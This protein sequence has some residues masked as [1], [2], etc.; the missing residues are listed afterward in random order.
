M[1]AA[2][3]DLQRL[4]WGDY[5]NIFHNYQGQ[6]REDRWMRAPKSQ[7]GVSIEDAETAMAPLEKLFW[8]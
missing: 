4:S 5:A 1:E 8:Q 6:G 3:G 7:E 2:A